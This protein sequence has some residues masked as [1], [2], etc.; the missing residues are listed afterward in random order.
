MIKTSYKES[1]L[2][3]IVFLYLKKKPWG[4]LTQN[5]VQTKFNI[6]LLWK[7]VWPLLNIYIYKI[8]FKIVLLFVLFS[9]WFEIIIWRILLLIILFYIW[10]FSCSVLLWK[11]TGIT[12]RKQIRKGQ[13]SMTIIKMAVLTEDKHAKRLFELVFSSFLLISQSFWQTLYF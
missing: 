6:L 10:L 13:L 4:T 1:Y 2:L 8:Y 7:W 12:Y 11:L 5:Y 3:F 9:V